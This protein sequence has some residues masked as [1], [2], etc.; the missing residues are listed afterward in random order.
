M[1]PD[2]T[3]S[4]DQRLQ[5]APGVS[6]PPGDWRIQFARSSGPG[7]QNVNKLNTR[8]QLW[9]RIDAMVGLT[10]RAKERL[11]I[12]AGSAR[13]S[14][15]QQEILLSSQTERS[16]ESNRREVLE[17]LRELVLR[18]RVEPK[19]RRKTRPSKASKERRIE[20]KK[21]RGQIKARRT[22]SSDDW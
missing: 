15:D 1:Q 5:I 21:R 8:A 6:V 9:I 2:D 10:H 3:T 12:L 22:G 4:S 18:A 20:S 19:V 16:Q 14:G 7:G 11:R 17:R 13:L